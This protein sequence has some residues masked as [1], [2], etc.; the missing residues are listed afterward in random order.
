LTGSSVRA[1]LLPSCQHI[2]P[3][4]AAVPTVSSACLFAHCSGA[5]K[6]AGSPTV[7]IRPS[8]LISTREELTALRDAIDMTLALPGVRE[9]LGQ[10]L[11]PA[12]T[13]PNGRDRFPPVP[14]PTPGPTKARPIAPLGP[15][16]NAEQRLLATLRNHPGSSV[17][18]LAKAAGASRSTTGER[19]KR[20]AAR[21]EI[22]K[23][24]DEQWRLKAEET[25]ARPTIA[26]SS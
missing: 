9:L 22:E 2:G 10:W 20:L 15:P 5:T 21:G 6:P 18:S 11:T 13:K 23:G 17:N 16:S 26:P 12:T 24:P 4:S 7:V 25:E 8:K 14:S 19:L 3:S 1:D